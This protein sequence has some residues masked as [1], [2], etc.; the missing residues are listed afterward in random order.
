[1]SRPVYHQP[2][3]AEG[4]RL[5]WDAVPVHIRAA[6]EGWLGSPIIAVKSQATGFSPGVA[7]RLTAADGRRIFTKA[8]GPEPNPRSVGI[9]RREAKITALLPTETPAP[10]L[11]WS[12]DDEGNSG[13]IVLAFED[14]DGKHPALPWAADELKRVMDALVRLSDILTPSPVQLGDVPTASEQ[15][16]KNIC[17]WR[18]LLDAPPTQIDQ[19]DGWSKRHLTQLAE[20]E[21]KTSAAVAG[22]TLLHIDI[23]ADNILL[24]PDKV[25]IIDWPHACLG[26]AWV[27][28]LCFAPS[29]TMQGGPLPE[30]LLALYPPIQQADGEAI[31]A[32]I[33]S[34]AG[35]FTYQA[36][37]PPP[38]GLPTVRAF[39]AAQGVV[40]RDWIAQR[41]GWR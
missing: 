29:V 38:P 8:I 5:Q 12:F 25:W 20:L 21:S 33:V 30:D 11:L 37:E 27:D 9:H 14:I 3:P 24:T 16:E 10:R 17:G 15:Y 28:V 31:T 4:V 22:N 7:A 13:W 32:A 18:K 2:P 26:A 23:R 1:M 6:V 36:L 39:Q 41:T 40:A 35:Y 19:L 34:T